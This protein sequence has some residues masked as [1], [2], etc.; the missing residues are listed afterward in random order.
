[1]DWAKDGVAITRGLT[2]AKLALAIKNFW[3]VFFILGNPQ[4]YIARHAWQRSIKANCNPTELCPQLHESGAHA[5]G[6]FAFA[7][8]FHCGFDLVNPDGE[9]FTL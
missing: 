9:I 6:S 2:N 1:V 7:A 3:N 4:G 8:T 5:A